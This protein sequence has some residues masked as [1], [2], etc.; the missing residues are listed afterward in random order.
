MLEIKIDFVQ[1]ACSV[2]SAYTFFLFHCLN[3]W[4]PLVFTSGLFVLLQVYFNFFKQSHET[5]VD[6]KDYISDLEVKLRETSRLNVVV[7]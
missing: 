5:A 1:A 2:L 3:A 7:R 6:C 4:L